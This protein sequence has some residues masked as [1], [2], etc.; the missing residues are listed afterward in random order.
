MNSKSAF[1]SAN[2][3]IVS[4]C[5][6]THYFVQSEHDT[7]KRKRIRII[8]LAVYLRS[9]FTYRIYTWLHYDFFLRETS[10]SR[11][12]L[13]ITRAS[14]SFLLFAEDFAFC[15]SGLLF[16]VFSSLHYLHLNKSALAYNSLC[17]SIYVSA[18]VL[19]RSEVCCIF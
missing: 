16:C 15:I 19:T 4:T 9:L 7:R 12:C 13:L 5:Q 14:F 11:I 17:S 18:H 2:Y 3:L 1:H 10:A 8:E 6:R